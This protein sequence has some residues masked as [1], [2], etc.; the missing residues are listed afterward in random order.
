MDS[1]GIII[2]S[3]LSIPLMMF[4]GCI[5]TTLVES[6]HRCGEDNISEDRI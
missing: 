2:L 6:Y 1:I 3:F 4:V 5:F